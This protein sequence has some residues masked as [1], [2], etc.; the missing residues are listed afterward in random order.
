MLDSGPIAGVN[1]A[2]VRD[3]LLPDDAPATRAAAV[4][5]ANFLGEPFY[6]ELRTRQQLGYIVGSAAA[7]SQ[8]QR[9]F[10]F[11]VQSS[12]YAPAELQK[13]AEAFIATLPAALAAITDAQWTTL[14]AGARATLATKPK[15][16]A[17]KAEE[18][19]GSAYTYDGEW[20]RRAAALAALDQL[21]REQA[22]TLLRSTL[23]SPATRQR[24]VL[25]ASAK[26]A[27]P[28]DAGSIGE[29]GPWKA[30]RQFR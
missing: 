28:T 17:D 8:R 3:Y 16:M 19:F 7:A 26:H 2:F 27:Q 13:R 23:A 30:T 25:L 14:V 9:F 5:L 20:E 1:S 22:L 4:V 10:T 11:I 6:A 18:F 12:E 24:T 21:T 15:N 29:R